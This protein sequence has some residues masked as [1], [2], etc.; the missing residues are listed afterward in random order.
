MNYIYYIYAYL[1]KSDGSPY[2]IG[3]G[4]GNRAYND[5]KHIPVPKD[6]SR[7]IIMETNLSELG[8]LALERRYI[9]WYGRKDLG[10]GILINKTDGGDGVSNRFKELNPFYGKI[11]SEKTKKIL[12]EAKQGSNNPM[13]GRSHKRILCE[14]CN[15]EIPVNTYPRFHGLNCKVIAS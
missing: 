1:R 8:A 2:Y 5:H 12:K 7:I 14:H 15:K 11:H 13:F 4:K 10:T 6:K 9:R 3:K